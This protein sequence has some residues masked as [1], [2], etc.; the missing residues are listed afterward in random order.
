MSDVGDVAR[1]A[2]RSDAMAAGAR[3]GLGAR[4]LIYL[5]MGLLALAV[6]FGRS[7]SE[8]DQRGALKAVAQ[9]S[10]GKALLVLLAVGFAAYA[11][12]RLSQAAFGV[13][14]DGDGAG[15]RVKALASGVVYAALA[16]TTV[17]V[18]AGS[19]GSTRQG[20]QQQALTARV[21]AH[22]GGRW[23]VGAAG[24]V[25]LGVS[26][27]MV[28]DGATKKFEKHLRMQ[29][30]TATTRSVV[31]KLGMVGTMARGVVMGLTGILVVQ[32][33]VQ[34]R[35]D[36]AR[37]LDGALRTL[38]GQPYGQTLLVLA[39]LGLVAFGV[40]GFAEARWYRT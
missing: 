18:L 39:A 22:S 16:V 14:G 23:L 3:L 12:W 25:L 2:S 1:R 27:V 13:P 8:T 15:P 30:M 36:K 32:A 10:G 29:E 6:A 35:P 26:A 7:A 28:Y 40:Y 11:V 20:D 4:G 17:S 21:M 9:H 33:A 24:L 31:G 5:L 19:G 37:G 34:F 38:A